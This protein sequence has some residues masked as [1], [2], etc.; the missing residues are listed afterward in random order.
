M[1]V[2]AAGVTVPQKT[3]PE[4]MAWASGVGEALWAGLVGFPEELQETW[5]GSRGAEGE[6]AVACVLQIHTFSGKV[7]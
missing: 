3:L 4:L 2:C 5:Q 7:A 6:G 1:S